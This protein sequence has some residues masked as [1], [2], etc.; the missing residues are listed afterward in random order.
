MDNYKVYMHLFPN[1]KKYIGI[2]K[3][4]LNERW[5]K[6]N[7]YRKN[8]LVYKAINKYGW[9]NIK[10]ISLLEN[11]SK[12][13]AENKEIELIAFY[14]SN[15][16][17]YGYNVANGGNCVGTVSEIT[18]QKLS[19]SKMGKLNPMYGKKGILN[20][21]YG[22]K[23]HPAWNKGLKNAYTTKCKGVSL[24][25]EHKEKLRQA[26]LRNPNRY[27]LGKKKDRKSVEL[28]ILKTSYKVICL[29]TNIIYPSHNEA[30]RQTKI[31]NIDRCCRKERKTAGG[32]HWEYIK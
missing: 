5:R 26:K 10:H 17:K 1:G 11:L 16:P 28:Q 14:K 9:D 27:W 19:K 13:Q 21:N 15:N 23:G 18:K 22:K 29:E 30:F 32:Y 3:Q 4:K 7:G 24:S 20:P 31:Y 8:S 12:E 6:G 2:T 25:K